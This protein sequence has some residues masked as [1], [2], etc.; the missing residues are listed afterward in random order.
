MD[1]GLCT[2]RLMARALDQ[3]GTLCFTLGLD[4]LRRLGCMDRPGNIPSLAGNLERLLCV[5]HHWSVSIVRVPLSFVN[6]L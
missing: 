4:A 2:L 6:F 5:F 1:Y 3:N